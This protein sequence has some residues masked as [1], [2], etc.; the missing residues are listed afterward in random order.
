[1]QYWQLLLPYLRQI[2][3]F[4]SNYYTIIYT[5][6]NYKI[7]SSTFINTALI[8]SFSILHLRP[9]FIEQQSYLMANT[10]PSN[11]I[12]LLLSGW[13][14]KTPTTSELKKLYKRKIH[15]VQSLVDFIFTDGLIGPLRCQRL[16]ELYVVKIN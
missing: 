3:F 7:K 9:P 15:K 6:H 5:I 1:M 12:R 13:L 11:K 8:Q 10:V 14:K 4:T 16:F 2:T